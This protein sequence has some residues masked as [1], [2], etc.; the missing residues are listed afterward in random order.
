MLLVPALLLL[1][2]AVPLLLL[3]PPMRMSA[4]ERGSP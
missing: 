3:G 1:P 2:T 4:D